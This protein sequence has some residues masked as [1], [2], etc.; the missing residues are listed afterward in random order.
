MGNATKVASSDTTVIVGVRCVDNKLGRWATVTIT[1]AGPEPLVAA[2][3][4]LL[5]RFA[6]L[7]TDPSVRDALG[8]SWLSAAQVMA[9]HN[10]VIEV[11]TSEENPTLTLYF[12]LAS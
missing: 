2:W 6:R 1:N 9:Q 5:E 4:M 8:L 7:S 10:G 12:P 3:R 11:S